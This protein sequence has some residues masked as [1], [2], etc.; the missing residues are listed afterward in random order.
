MEID[1]L[2]ELTQKVFETIYFKLNIHFSVH[3][4]VFCISVGSSDSYDIFI[5][6]RKVKI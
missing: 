3:C 6:L 4:G 1:I 5:G 2:V